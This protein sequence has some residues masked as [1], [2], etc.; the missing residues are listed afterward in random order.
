MS[1][2][3]LT[4]YGQHSSVTQ[5]CQSRALACPNHYALLSSNAFI[6]YALAAVITRLTRCLTSTAHLAPL[7]IVP[8]ARGGCLPA[9]RP[10]AS[11]VTSISL[12]SAPGLPAALMARDHPP[13]SA[14]QCRCRAAIAGRSPWRAVVRC[15]AAPPLAMAA[16]QAV[17]HLSQEVC[18]AIQAPH[19]NAYTR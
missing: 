14:H 7:L 2:N 6:A 9:P 19:Y 16:H 1:K 8:M 10:Q 11:L 13:L 18:D 17:R 15:G 3:A 4:L 12:V 5:G